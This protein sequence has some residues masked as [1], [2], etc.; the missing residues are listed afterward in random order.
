MA[1]VRI[2]W[3]YA[4]AWRRLGSTD[5]TDPAGGVSYGTGVYGDGIYGG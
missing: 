1:R 5:I 4:T 3:R 2:W